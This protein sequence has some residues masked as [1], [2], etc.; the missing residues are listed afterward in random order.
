MT[1]AR[2]PRPPMPINQRHISMV[3]QVHTK[4]AGKKDTNVTVRLIYAT[5]VVA[6]SVRESVFV[7]SFDIA[8]NIVPPRTSQVPIPI[9]A[10]PGR[11]IISMPIKPFTI[12]TMPSK[13]ANMPTEMTI[14]NIAR[15]F[16]VILIW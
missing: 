14:R 6:L 1:W 5:M 15:L 9:S 3:G 12:F 16:L 2:L 11:R 4:I 13:Q 7:K 10:K 8:T